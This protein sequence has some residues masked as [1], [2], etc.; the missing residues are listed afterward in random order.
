[1]KKIKFLI[2]YGIFLCVSIATLKPVA[3]GKEVEYII[4]DC[5]ALVQDATELFKQYYTDNEY[6]LNS[7]GKYTILNTNIKKLNNNAELEIINLE[8]NIQYWTIAI[9]N[10]YSDLAVEE[11]NTLINI[12]ND[13][14]EFELAFS[15]LSGYDNENASYVDTNSN[16]KINKSNLVNRNIKK[17]IGAGSASIV[18][19]TIASMVTGINASS[20]IPFV[21]WT[22]ATVLVA[23]LIIYIV[24][25][26]SYVKE[27]YNSFI[28]TLKNKY[29]R[30][31]NLLSR[32]SEQ[33]MEESKNISDV[34]DNATSPN[35][36]EKQVEKGQAPDE[37]DRVDSAHNNYGQPHVHFKDGTSLNRDGTIHDKGHGMPNP[38]N[39][40]W[41]WLHRNGWCQNGI[42]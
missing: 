14:P 12:K 8:T 35:Q 15:L 25:N 32:T 1:M 20:L 28:E 42:K 23:S 40:V 33:V 38:S 26:W 2:I 22:V 41:D 31:A 13:T 27:R 19:S 24:A 4:D 10:I 18:F 6:Y 9:E 36:M 37:V 7:E 34:A 21:G 11:Q 29:P 17:L 5:N 3:I 39:K 16:I 30:I